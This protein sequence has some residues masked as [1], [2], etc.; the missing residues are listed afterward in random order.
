MTTPEQEVTA[1]ARSLE[2]RMAA[3]EQGNRVRILRARLKADL[4]KGARSRS[5]A[6]LAIRPTS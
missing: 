6:F 3:L 5:Q 2:Q 4:R 1:P